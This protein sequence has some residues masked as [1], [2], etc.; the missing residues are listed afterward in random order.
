MGTFEKMSVREKLDCEYEYFFLDM[1]RTSRENLFSH[2]HEIE[3]KRTILKDVRIILEAVS[4]EK[5]TIMFAQENLLNA[6]YCYVCEHEDDGK[7]IHTLIHNWYE[8]LTRER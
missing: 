5:E 7:D 4:P 8:N 3:V 1:M 6:V 2:S